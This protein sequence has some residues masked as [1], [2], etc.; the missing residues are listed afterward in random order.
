[1]DLVF[2]YVTTKDRA[3]A[4]RIGRTIVEER[5]AACANVLDGMHSFYWWKGELCEDDEAVLIAKTR[6]NLV[7]AVTARI[8][9]LHGYETPCVVALPL[10]GGNLDFLA[11]IAAETRPQS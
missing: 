6:K 10:A 8:K 3:E 1:M 11:W 5:L 7:D 2:L 9:Q 4:L